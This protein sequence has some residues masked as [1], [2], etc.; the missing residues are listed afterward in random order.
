MG[1]HREYPPWGS[2]SGPERD[3]EPPKRN[4]SAAFYLSGRIMRMDGKVGSTRPG[5]YSGLPCSPAC[6][7]VQQAR[8][9]RDLWDCP[10]ESARGYSLPGSQHCPRL[11][12]LKSN[13]GASHGQLVARRPRG[14]RSADSTRRRRPQGCPRD[15]PGK[16]R[17]PMDRRKGVPR[18]IPPPLE[19]ARPPPQGDPAPMGRTP[20]HHLRRPRA[21]HAT[22]A[23]LRPVHH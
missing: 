2:I 16:P 7:A 12:T 11:S 4:L 1:P 3:R 17:L 14:A 19:L 22:M 6:G 13:S 23:A 10:G 18:R 15:P 9:R 20:V 21:S 5:S 8:T